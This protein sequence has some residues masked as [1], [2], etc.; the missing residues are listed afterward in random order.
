MFVCFGN[1]ALTIMMRSKLR[2]RMNAIRTR[3]KELSIPEDSDLYSLKD[4]FKHLWAIKGIIILLMALLIPMD[5]LA[6]VDG[7]NLKVM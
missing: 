3:L 6:T 5:L 4:I 1:H 2:K 7:H